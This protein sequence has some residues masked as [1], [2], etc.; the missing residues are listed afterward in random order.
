MLTKFQSLKGKVQ[1]LEIILLI[2]AS[3]FIVAIIAAVFFGFII[4]V[5]DIILWALRGF[6]DFG[7]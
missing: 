6:E 2:L 4:L 5:V 1:P 7:L 3:P